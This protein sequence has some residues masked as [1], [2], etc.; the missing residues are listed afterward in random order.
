MMDRKNAEQE[1]TNGNSAKQPT[2]KQPTRNQPTRQQPTRE[3]PT[4][5]ATNSSIEEED[6]V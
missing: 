6:E 4:K 1:K 3:Q 5:Q 2:R